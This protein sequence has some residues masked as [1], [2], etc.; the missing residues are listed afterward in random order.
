MCIVAFAAC[1]TA[2]L[3]PYTM[4][5]PAVCRTLCATPAE[6]LAAFMAAFAVCV[7]ACLVLDPGAMAALA[8]SPTR[9]AD[10]E[11]ALFEAFPSALATCPAVV[12]AA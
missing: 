11:T 7:S 6:E 3:A 1:P 9:F 12:P 4:G 5:G 2:A 8:L 10:D